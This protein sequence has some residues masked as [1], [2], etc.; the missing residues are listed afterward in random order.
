MKIVIPM[1]GKSE[2]YKKAGFNKPKFL[3]PVGEKSMIEKVVDT[4]DP[5]KDEYVFIISKQPEGDFRVREFLQDLPLKK[6]IFEIPPHDL[7]PTYS[8]LQIGNEL[9]DEEEVIVN[10][11]DFVMNWDY[12]EFLRRIRQSGYDGAIPSFR[13]FHPAS[14]GNTYY[15]YLKVNK[16]NELA[17][18]REKQPFTENRLNEHASTGTYYFKKWKHVK[19][20]GKQQIDRNI[21]AGKEYYP[22]LI[23]NLMVGA[24]LKILVYEVDK[25]ICLGTPEDYLQHQYWFNYFQ[26]KK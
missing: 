9:A 13:G 15:A 6:K 5:V 24:G 16:N 18:L 25:F 12:Q 7:G 22:S 4:F 14:L 2:R 11:C 10:Y 17:E 1:A 3:L 21:K 23:Y 8:L 26:G 19:D 20:F